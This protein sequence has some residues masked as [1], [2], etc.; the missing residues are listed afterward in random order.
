MQGTIATAQ[1]PQDDMPRNKNKISD[2]LKSEDAVERPFVLTH[3]CDLWVGPIPAQG[4]TM[5][6][7]SSLQDPQ[8][9]ACAERVDRLPNRTVVPAYEQISTLTG[10]WDEFM[11]AF[12]A[13]FCCKAHP[14][15]LNLIA[16]DSAFDVS[17][18]HAMLWSVDIC[19]RDIRPNNMMW[20]TI[21]RQ[22]KLCEFDLCLFPDT[23]ELSA[24][25]QVVAQQNY[26]N[27]GTCIFMEN[28]LLTS[29]AMKYR[30]KRVYRHEVESFIAVL[31]WFSCQYEDGKLLMPA[32][33]REWVRRDY[34]L[35]LS[36][37][38]Y[39]YQKIMHRT[40]TRPPCLD[41]ELWFRIA[42]TVIDLI[43]FLASFGSASCRHYRYAALLHDDP[44]NVAAIQPRESLDGYNGLR[45]LF[46]ILTWPIFEHP[47]AE[48]FAELLKRHIDARELHCGPIRLFCPENEEECADTPTNRVPYIVATPQFEAIS[49]LTNNW[50]DF[51][52]AFITLFCG[53]AMLWSTGIRCHGIGE[54][55]L[56]W[57]P[58][59]KKPK[60]RDF[61]LSRLPEAPSTGGE[62][63][64][65]GPRGYSDTGTWIFMANELLTP[66]AME[67]QVKRV[68]RHEV[69]S[70][71]AVLLWVTCQYKGEKLKTT[72]PLDDW[73]Q[74]LYERILSQRNKTYAQITNMAFTRPCN[75]DQDLWLDISGTIACL[76]K[77]LHELG[78]TRNDQWIYEI[79][80][81]RNSRRVRAAVKPGVSTEDFD[82][83]R[84]LLKVFTWP[85]FTHPVAEPLIELT[86][87]YI[88]PDA[89]DTT[90]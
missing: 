3:P 67:G 23:R 6:E 37:R 86:K 20:D 47:S 29:Y 4:I 87:E 53:H 65:I 78:G 63:R 60:L 34:V 1:T 58:N 36:N 70:F 28:E 61:D 25:E 62:E 84:S 75:L 64:S 7:S 89:D 26:S 42:M 90:Q 43:G 71:I 50:D 15:P 88:R 41:E 35:I 74:T 14:F 33:L 72:A 9:N 57:D 38:D 11:G 66:L 44:P 51:M 24:E 49:T 27:T 17:A 52:G 45:S 83:L 79:S 10:D 82:G 18:G 16:A 19:H 73:N 56:L 22:A 39:T 13:I 68:Y 30:V 77:F 32:P 69:E 76:N 81:Q 2:E 40:F 5:S 48:R 46:K 21:A 59:A 55:N 54:N 12:S 31:V 80:L 85:I 8:A